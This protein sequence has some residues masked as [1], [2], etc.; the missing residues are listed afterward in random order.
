VPENAGAAARLEALRRQ[1]I[2]RFFGRRRYGDWLREA[3]AS[4]L[5]KSLFEAED[6]PPQP[7]TDRI[8][9]HRTLTVVPGPRDDI[10]FVVR[11][12][13]R[14]LF[15]EG[16]LS[17]RL[18]EAAEGLSI[19]TL[20]LAD[21]IAARAHL[22]PYLKPFPPGDIVIPPTEDLARL[23]DALLWTQG[24]LLRLGPAAPAALGTLAQLRAAPLEKV[25]GAWLVTA[26]DDLLPSLAEALVS[27]FR[28][29]GKFEE[30]ERRYD[31]AVFANATQSLLR[32]GFEATAIATS[33]GDLEASSRLFIGPYGSRIHLLGVRNQLEIVAARD[34]EGVPF[35]PLATLPTASHVGPEDLLLTVGQPFSDPYFEGRAGSEGPWEL[36]IAAADLEVISHMHEG[37]DGRLVRFARAANLAR[38]RVEL[39]RYSTLDEYQEFALNAE[40]FPWDEQL[41]EQ[42]AV[43]FLAPG[44]AMPFRLACAMSLDRHA[45]PW[46]QGGTVEGSRRYFGD[47]VPIYA[48]TFGGP[49]VGRCVIVGDRSVWVTASRPGIGMPRQAWIEDATGMVEAAA[50]WTW[51]VTARSPEDFDRLADPMTIEIVIPDEGLKTVIFGAPSASGIEVRHLA[52]DHLEIRFRGA[53]QTVGPTN[54]GDQALARALLVGLSRATGRMLDGEAAGEVVAELAGPPTRKFIAPIDLAWNSLI[55]DADVPPL[56]RLSSADIDQWRDPLGAALLRRGWHP[57]DISTSDDGSRV[58]RDAASEVMDLLGSRI[59]EHGPSLLRELV[60]QVESAYRTEA[61]ARFNYTAFAAAFGAGSRIA[62][63]AGADLLAA[64]NPSQAL[65]F[66]IEYTVAVPPTGSRAVDS[67]GLDSLM[68]GASLLIELGLSADAKQFFLPESPVSIGPSGRLKYGADLREGMDR[69]NAGFRRKAFESAESRHGEHWAPLDPTPSDL[70]DLRSIGDAYAAEFGF[71]LEAHGQFLNAALLFADELGPSVAEADRATFVG[72]LASTLGWSE[73]RVSEVLE[74]LTLGTRAS[75]SEV[76]PGYAISD[77]YPWRFNRAL[78]YVRRPFLATP[79]GSILFGTRHVYRSGLYLFGVVASGRYRARSLQMQQLQGRI[80]GQESAAFVGAV[81]DTCRNRG[82]ETRSGIKR[83]AG[84]RIAVDGKDLGDIDV[85]AFNRATSTLWLIECKALEVARTPW[86]L[87]NEMRK[88]TAAGGAVDRHLRRLEWVLANG[89]AVAKDIGAGDQ[90]YA[91][92]AVIVTP[93]GAMAKEFDRPELEILSFEDLG[94]TVALAGLPRARR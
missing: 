53:I 34:G 70:T 43:V 87:H 74:A 22:R 31:E 92:Q 32:M 86:E 40:S 39:I 28:S 82:L 73:A 72:A 51:Q 64:D 66:L 76:P 23:A 3:V 8:A 41:D 88:L 14:A 57:A 78:S 58:L 59:A 1:P 50:Y 61:V 5:A 29:G 79:S 77:I 67:A 94:P 15:L 45:L 56:R 17:K 35:M 16:G 42:N 84:Q 2:D 37:E 55:A 18:R 13:T 20:N 21:G 71:T 93:F 24:D 83:M 62:H 60:R 36:G 25:G 38:T 33:S 69:F 75:F 54:E 11:M 9:F 81:L 90:P 26:P 12:L 63:V 80:A 27:L 68:A 7:F 19:A 10:A 65:R 49:V 48:M 85:L 52:R 89:A 47:E 6:H 4:P 46:P 91:V 44:T 30:L